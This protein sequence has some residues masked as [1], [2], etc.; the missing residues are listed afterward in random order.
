MERFYI[1]LLA[2]CIAIFA[3][4]FFFL[5]K[6]REY[7]SNKK[8]INYNTEWCGYSKQFQPIWDKFTSEMKT[9]HP[10]IEVVDMK[11]D[12]AENEVKCKIPEVHGFPTVVLFD[13]DN[14]KVFNDDRTVE[15]LL[16]FVGK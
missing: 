15:K 5:N 16:A 1:L 13:G 14:K 8:I 4:I 6:K 7:M 12:K 11:C 9:K 10:E 2:L 3:F